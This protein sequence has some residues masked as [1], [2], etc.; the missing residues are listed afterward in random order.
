MWGSG[1]RVQGAGCRVQGA[2]FRVQGAGFR[3]QGA[4]CRVWGVGCRADRWADVARVAEAR[5]EADA[6]G[7]AVHACIGVWGSD[8]FGSRVIPNEATQ[9]L[10]QQ[11]IMRHKRDN[12]KNKVGNVPGGHAWHCESDH[13]DV[14]FP[15]V[16][17]CTHTYTHTGLGV[18]THTHTHTDRHPPTHTHTHTHRIQGLGCRVR[19]EGVSFRD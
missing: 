15:N 7:R 2:G 3:V 5:G 19:V 14:T 10:H 9:S 8:F 4:G 16:D 12:N 11:C 18:R 6:G 17:T 1:C 13:A